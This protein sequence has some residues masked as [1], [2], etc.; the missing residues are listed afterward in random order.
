MICFSWYEIYYSMKKPQRNCKETTKKMQ[1]NCKEIP[2]TALTAIIFNSFFMY[3][4]LSIFLFSNLFLF[5]FFP[6]YFNFSCFTRALELYLTLV[7][8]EFNFLLKDM[9]CLKKNW[10]KSNFHFFLVKIDADLLSS[11]ANSSYLCKE[12]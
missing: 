1:R 3:S 2:K 9:I 10:K 8:I 6:I 5:S 11:I 7:H 12:I 4:I